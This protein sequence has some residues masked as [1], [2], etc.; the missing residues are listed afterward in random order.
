MKFV[1][2]SFSILLSLQSFAQEDS[3]TFNLSGLKDSVEIITDHWGI[4]HIYASNEEDLFFA[5]GFY[6][7]KDRIFQFE[8]W[9]RQATGTTAEILGEKALERD[10]GTRLFQFRGDM[11][12]EMNYYHPKGK[13]IIEAYVAGVNAYIQDIRNRPDDL[14]IEFRLLGILPE[15]WTPE[16]VISRHQG[17]LGNIDSEINTARAIA[18]IGVDKVK[19]LAW[20]HPQ[21]PDLNIDPS[22]DVSLLKD[23][24]IAP[25]H[26]FRRPLTFSPDD[27]VA[28]AFRND[29]ELYRTWASADKTAYDQW[30]KEE[31]NDIGSNNW[32]IN[33][34]RTES[35]YPIMANDPHRRLSTP[36]LRY[37]SHLVA[38]GWNVIGGGEPEI[39]GISIGHNEY[40]AWGL[41]VY[42]TDAEDLYVYQLNPENSHEY[43]Y[44][45]RF[46]PMQKIMD[47]IQVRD[48]GAV[49][50]VHL[51]TKHGPVTKIDGDNNVGYAMRC[52]W[53]EV[54]GSP[55]LA[56]LRMD[57]AKNWSEFQEACNYSHIP[58]ENMVWS[59]REGNIGWQAVGIAPV[60]QGFSGMVPLPGDGRFEWSGYMPIIA[61]PWSL[62]PQ[63]GII[64]TSNENVTPLDYPYWDAVGYQWSDPYR[65]DRVR[66]VLE[67][68]QQHSL[69]DMAALQTDYYSIPARQILPLYKHVQTDDRQLVEILKV[70][71]S[72]D[73]QMTPES[74]AA[75]IYQELEKQLKIYVTSV[76]V[77]ESVKDY[78]SIPMKRIIEWLYLPDGDFGANPI[79][80]RNTLLLQALYTALI[81]LTE[82]LGPDL[83]KWRYGS[84]ENKHALIKHPLSNA[85]NQDLRDRLNV[86]PAPRGGNSYTV[87][88]TGGNLNQP[89]GGSFRIIV[90]NANWDHC[91]ATN[92][93]GQHGDPEHEHYD[94]LFELWATD[95][96][97]PLFYSKDKVLS[98]QSYKTV[99]RPK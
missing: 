44:Q 69:A 16:V 98:V 51:Y 73:Y 6:A 42:R 18:E 83:K 15:F 58:G 48:L 31:L 35:G 52:G 92:S 43:W 27:L 89:S 99:L 57:Q 76:K 38:P 11:D 19:E 82:R 96:Y 78:L 60:R 61:K 53:L 91:L 72:W 77:P 49:P 70:L 88:N 84:A 68:G 9:R 64:N 46:M 7:A 41:T 87:N 40:G 90:D 14:P 20:F 75:A 74:L 47:T 37:M 23:D 66:E 54:G 29:D 56:S 97:F 39:P 36:S 86:G 67:N 30:L 85:V 21:D 28:A 50:V 8:I 2:F 24:V 3:F 95:Q 93:P 59:D 65:G 25:Y 32:V 1:L 71:E 80:T 34:N 17:L 13:M 26:A 22:I 45:G 62:N 79:E 55:Y 33:G 63:D 4:P 81:D 5:Q 12:Q 94:N 10:I